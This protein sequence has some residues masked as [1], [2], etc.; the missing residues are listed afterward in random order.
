MRGMENIPTTREAAAFPCS[1]AADT[2]S[3]IVAAAI[4]VMLI[5]DVLVA[6]MVFGESSAESERKIPCFN[7]RFS[8]TAWIADVS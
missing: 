3:G 2:L 6:S 1:D 4:F 5:E 8:E 7:A